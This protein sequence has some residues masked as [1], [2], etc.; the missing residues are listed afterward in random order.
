MRNPTPFDIVYTALRDSYDSEPLEQLTRR[1]LGNLTE[2][3]FDPGR[4]PSDDELTITEWSDD[5]LHRELDSYE[6]ELA[7]GWRP[8]PEQVIFRK[9]VEAETRRRAEACRQAEAGPIEWVL[10]PRHPTDAMARA[11]RLTTDLPQGGRVIQWGSNAWAAMLAAA[12]RREEPTPADPPPGSQPATGQDLLDTL[13]QEHEDLVRKL[14][15]DSVK[16]HDTSCFD[17][18]Y[19]SVVAALSAPGQGSS[20]EGAE[21]SDLRRVSSEQSDAD[22]GG[23]AGAVSTPSI[24]YQYREIG[25]GQDWK[26]CSYIAYL[27]YQSD[28]HIDTRQLVVEPETGEDWQPMDTAPRDGTR[29][30]IRLRR[31]SVYAAWQVRGDSEHYPTG[32]VADTD[33][34]T[35]HEGWALGWM[36]LSASR[37]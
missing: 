9:I 27:G 10:V 2:A 34:S 33:G 4:K 18:A 26:S 25:E 24:V 8:S 36:P 29:V 15:N 21:G 20:E 6:R 23:L 14:V 37:S 19:D 30:R 32:W 22:I 11:S 3:G 17:R 31:G 35:F 7:K 13:L 28:P 12:P 1:V 16:I 5:D